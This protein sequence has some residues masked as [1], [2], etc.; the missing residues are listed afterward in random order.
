VL[1]FQPRSVVDTFSPEIAQAI[2]E[3]LSEQQYD[4][5][6]A[7]QL[8]MAAYY[9]Y[10]QNVSAIFEELEIGLFHDQAFSTNG[11]IRFRQAL[12]WF[13]LR[14]Y[15]SRLLDS[16]QA[17]TVASAQE[18]QLVGRS[19]PRYKN[20]I[21]VIP[22]CLNAGEYKNITAERKPNTL[23]FTGPFTYR[24]NYDA[25][26]WFVGEVFPLI[27]KEVPGTQLIITGDHSN[28]P[29]PS[30]DNVTL[31]GYVDDIKTLVA[32]CTISIAPLLSGGGTRLKIL[33]AM[34]LETP[35]VSTSKGAEGLE[36]KDGEQILIADT[37]ADY[38]ECVI[39]LLKDENMRL[40][41]VRK[42]RILV[43]EKYNWDEVLSDYFGLI[44]TVV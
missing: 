18:Q 23:I 44:N 43:Q 22:N 37:P 35:V 21:E 5:V 3:F 7:S 13:K 15:L 40:Q 31:A 24:A 20:P 32:S 9:P 19:F 42:A 2:T 1:S 6:I 16:F 17:C 10:F 30:S 26:L 33:E 36:V 34:A 41:L 12:T 8:Q 38:T 27:L 29:L 14:R 28:L 25:M 39:R 11:N 4:L